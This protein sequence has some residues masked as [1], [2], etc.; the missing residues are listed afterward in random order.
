MIPLG[1]INV[2]SVK[3]HAHVG[4]T[5]LI[6][7]I[8]YFIAAANA[9]R[10]LDPSYKMRPTALGRILLAQVGSSLMAL[11]SLV[12]L[13]WPAVYVSGKLFLSPASA[14]LDDVPGEVAMRRSWDVTTNRFWQTLGFALLLDVAVLG[15]E[16]VP[17][18]S[19]NGIVYAVNHYWGI[20]LRGSGLE[21][22]YQAIVTPVLLFAIQARWLGGLYWYRSL[23]AIQE[24]AL[25]EAELSTLVQTAESSGAAS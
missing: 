9:M 5:Y 17:P 3:V 18:F 25:A 1:L 8:W 16:M 11:C 13:I 6:S 15:A 4:A 10:T 24:G 12:F 14:L 22:V 23:R 21:M 7:F 19:L 20:D 2:L